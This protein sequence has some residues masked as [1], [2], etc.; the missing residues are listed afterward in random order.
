MSNAMFLVATALQTV[1]GYVISLGIVISHTEAD[2]HQAQNGRQIIT[3]LCKQQPRVDP[4][5]WVA[6][7]RWDATV[8]S[9]VSTNEWSHGMAQ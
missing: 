5:G 7:P 1:L 6:V 2:L 3:P 9:R 4:A 8:G